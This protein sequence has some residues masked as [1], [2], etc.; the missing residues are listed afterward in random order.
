MGD[1]VNIVA[2]LKGI[3]RPGSICLSEEKFRLDLAV[4]DLGTTQLKNIVEPFSGGRQAH[5]V[6]AGQSSPA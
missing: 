5:F 4:S 1:G 6:K 2:R 3:A